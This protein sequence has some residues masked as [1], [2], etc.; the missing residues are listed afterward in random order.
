MKDK[1]IKIL[2]VDD[3]PD[4]LEIISYNLTAQGYTVFT[5]NNGQKA[6]EKAKKEKP[7][8]NSFTFKAIFSLFFAVVNSIKSK[9]ISPK[10]IRHIDEA[11]PQAPCLQNR[12]SY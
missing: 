5:A 3:E 12:D 1:N 6:I 2:L 9:L 11:S 7:H 8:V 4:I 10:I